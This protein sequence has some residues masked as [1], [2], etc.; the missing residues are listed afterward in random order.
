MVNSF[1]R[2]KSPKNSIGIG[3]KGRVQQIKDIL[4]DRIIFTNYRNLTFVVSRNLGIDSIEQLENLSLWQ[5]GSNIAKSTLYESDAV[6]YEISDK[7]LKIL[8]NNAT[9][10]IK[11]LK[12]RYTNDSDRIF[13]D[14]TAIAILTTMIDDN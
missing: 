14:N 10:G 5:S 12:S 3:Y 7:E 9:Y 8:N 4:S 2:N 13:F 11:V 1:E 6:I